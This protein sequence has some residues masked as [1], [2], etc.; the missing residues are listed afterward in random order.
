MKIKKNILLTLSIMTVSSFVYA[1]DAETV[2]H[3][4]GFN[5]FNTSTEETESLLNNISNNVSNISGSISNTLNNLYTSTGVAIDTNCGNIKPVAA[6]DSCDDLGLSQPIDITQ[7]PAFYKNPNAGCDLSLALPGLPSWDMSGGL[8][9]SL[10]GFDLCAIANNYL[11]EVSGNI[12]DSVNSALSN[13]FNLD[14]NGNFAGASTGISGGISLGGTTQNQ[15]VTVGGAGSNFG[16]TITP[17]NQN[18]PVSTLTSGS[19]SVQN[20]EVPSRPRSTF[21]SLYE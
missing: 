21:S 13:S 15:T 4:P 3:Q 17:Q 19:G 12:T 6:L 8:D 2:T 16:T 14:Q 20:T 10:G 5:S 7:H 11:Q 1:N 9:F 18:V